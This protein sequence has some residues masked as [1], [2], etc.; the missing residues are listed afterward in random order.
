ML[1]QNLDLSNGLCNGTR[2]ICR[3]FG[4][5]I[6]YA[7]VAMGKQVFI[8]RI[9]LSPPNDEG[10][11]FKFKRKQFPIQLCFAMTINSTRT[12]ISKCWNIS[13]STCIFTWTTLRYI[14]KESFN[15]NNIS[16]YLVFHTCKKYCLFHKLSSSYTICIII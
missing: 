4:R 7:E 15:V 10:Y 6:I 2:M 16:P 8:P 3:S 12:N 14:V 11:P 13:T 9:P 5:N 1:L